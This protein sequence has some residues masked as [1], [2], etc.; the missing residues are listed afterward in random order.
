MK[1]M[2]SITAGKWVYTL[3]AGKSLRSAIE[4]E[5]AEDTIQQ[6]KSCWREINEKFPEEFD[7]YDLDEVL[8]DL[9]NER[10]NV[11][12]YEDYDMTYEDVEDDINYYL[13]DLYDFCDAYNIW[14]EGI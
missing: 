7:E 1:R 3:K 10:D 11:L 2:K 12:N 9:D 5:D 13:N 4:S 8:E 14:V 6:L